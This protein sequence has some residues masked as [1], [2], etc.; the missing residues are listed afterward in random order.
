[1]L[2]DLPFDELKVDR[3][4][5]AGAVA[6]G[7]DEA[8][9]RAVVGLAHRLGFEVVA[10]GVEDEATARLLAEAGYDLL[11]GYRFSRPV[12]A[13]E[14]RRLDFSTS[15]APATAL[16][17]ALEQSRARSAEEHAAA[18]GTGDPVLH[19][20][21]AVAARVAGT[22]VAAVTFIGDQQHVTA[23]TGV[24]PFTGP[25]DRSFCRHALEAGD[26]LQVPDTT[27]DARFRDLP[28]VT[29]EPRVRFYAGAPITDVAGRLLGTV[30]VFDQRPRTL[31][32]AQQ[33]SLRALARAA[34]ARLASLTTSTGPAPAAPAAGP[35]R[36]IPG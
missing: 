33:E 8:I 21:T 26:L 16:A 17:P 3:R 9:V 2:Q 10:E 1:M 31:D 34:S 19:E 14:L 28:M 25:R 15:P 20:L 7:G 29:G 18:A 27:T 6:G 4:F 13:E 30:C 11:Q 22:P 36:L 24:A 23:T 12:P 5:V 35:L 32:A